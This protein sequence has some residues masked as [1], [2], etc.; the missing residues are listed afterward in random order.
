[1]LDR[2]QVEPDAE[3]SVADLR[4]SGACKTGVGAGNDRLGQDQAHQSI[5]ICRKPWKS[6][7]DASDHKQQLGQAHAAARVY[8]CHRTTCPNTRTCQ[9]VWLSKPCVCEGLMTHRLLAT[10]TGVELVPEHKT[11][12]S[13]TARCAPAAR[14]CS[15]QPRPS[16]GANLRAEK[17][18]E[19]AL[20]PILK[21]SNEMCV[22]P[23]ICR[24]RRTV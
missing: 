3:A 23:N 20:A 15:Y 22:W 14:G 12:C 8:S 24:R 2:S 4:H 18:P 21:N 9:S 17:E 11:A 5:L 10:T 6:H 19:K 13:H 1:M 7:A 16:P